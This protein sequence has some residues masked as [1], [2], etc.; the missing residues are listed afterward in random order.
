[1][2]G[3]VHN[4]KERT[5]LKFAL[6]FEASKDASYNKRLSAVEVFANEGEH[7]LAVVADILS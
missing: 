6:W 4:E 7:L 5:D 1:M 2:Y 3:V